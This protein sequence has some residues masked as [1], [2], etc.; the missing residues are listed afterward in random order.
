MARVLIVDDVESE[1][2]RMSELLR[3]RGHEC[4]EAHDGAQ[5]YYLAKTKQPDVI[6]L[7][8]IMGGND[9]FS[10]CRRLKADQETENIPVVFVTG[11]ADDNGR[12]WGL[13][14]GAADYLTKPVAVE[15][16]VET[17]QRLA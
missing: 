11:Q 1:V 17:V 12:W 9:G 16:L 4:L 8:V 2:T 7:D 10:T 5:A 3:E 13:R 15:T 14:I 6:L